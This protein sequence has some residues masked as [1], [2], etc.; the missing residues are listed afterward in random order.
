[1]FFNIILIEEI[2]IKIHIRKYVGGSCSKSSKRI[3]TR[4]TYRKRLL[5]FPKFVPVSQPE[6]L[7]V[8]VLEDRAGSR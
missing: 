4:D 8:I 7:F 3:V 6:V 2:C 1:M 5:N